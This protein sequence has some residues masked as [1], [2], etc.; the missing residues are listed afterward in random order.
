MAKPVLSTG[1]FTRPGSASR[2]RR[3]SP[4]RTDTS[5]PPAD[6]FQ[7]PCPPSACAEIAAVDDGSGLLFSV[8]WSSPSAKAWYSPGDPLDCDPAADVWAASRPRLPPPRQRSRARSPANT[9]GYTALAQEQGGNQVAVAVE[10]EEPARLNDCGLLKRSATSTRPTF[11]R[12]DRS[13]IGCHR[14]RGIGLAG[15]P[16]PKGKG[17]F[18][19]YPTSGERFHF[20][21]HA[22]L[23]ALSTPPRSRCRESYAST[24]CARRSRQPLPCDRPHTH[25][26]F[27]QIA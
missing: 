20:R 5:S 12:S 18:R 16:K 21:R 22:A 2:L 11:C 23:K 3:R 13:R 6:P 14:D 25:L 24:R 17:K 10:G 4:T 1:R 27:G 19:R 26:F 8:V 9:F 7:N 15:L